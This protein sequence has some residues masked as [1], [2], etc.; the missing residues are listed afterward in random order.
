MSICVANGCIVNVNKS[1][2]R[3]E[4]HGFYWFLIVMHRYQFS[5][6]DPIPILFTQKWPIP[7]RYRCLVYFIVYKHAISFSKAFGVKTFGMHPLFDWRFKLML[8]PIMAIFMVV[9]KFYALK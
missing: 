9:L 3:E 4:P 5:P 2:M 7:I 8:Y 1:Y 6:T